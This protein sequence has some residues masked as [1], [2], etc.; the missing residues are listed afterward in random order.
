VLNQHQINPK[1]ENTLKQTIRT[2]IG[3][4]K[5]I[6]LPMDIWDDASMRS[7]LGVMA[8]GIND[9]WE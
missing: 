3:Q 8:H 1:N 7:F 6:H 4:C 9:K 5:H 2:A